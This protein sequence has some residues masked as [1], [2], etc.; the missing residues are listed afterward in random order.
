MQ[1]R[2]AAGKSILFII[3]T[4]SRLWSSA[5]YVFA[6]GFE[7]WSKTVAVLSGYTI[8]AH[9]EKG[10]IIPYAADFE[11]LYIGDISEDICVKAPEQIKIISKRNYS[12]RNNQGLLLI[13]IFD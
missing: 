8:G 10:V 13:T 5:R 11:I 7:T 12:V 9:T 4:I 1:W 3:G 2:S 6:R